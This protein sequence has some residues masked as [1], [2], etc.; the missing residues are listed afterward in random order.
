MAARGP[1][2]FHIHIFTGLGRLRARQGPAVVHVDEEPYNPAA[3]HAVLAARRSGAKAIF[4]A[5]QNIYR[6]YPAPFR[7]LEA[8]TYRA[9]AGAVAG[10]AAAGAILRRK[11]FRGPLWVVPQFGVDMKAF[12]PAAAA[13]AKAPGAP[14]TIGCVGRLVEAKGVD[15]VLDA[16]A[17][18]E[19]D[20]RLAVAGE[21]PAR[22]ALEDRARS[23]AV[24]PR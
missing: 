15:L 10:T 12:A 2:S 4:F 8:Y 17:G 14:F 13:G 24:E 21:G 18:L 23:L 1:G 9:A 16:V 22:R 19:A 20:W 11:G 3:A 5:W 6:Q 7:A